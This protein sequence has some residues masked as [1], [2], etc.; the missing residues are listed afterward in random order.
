M[1]RRYGMRRLAWLLTT[2][3]AGG[4]LLQTS[5]TSIIADGATGLATSI[6]D[7]YIRN[8]IYQLLNLSSISS[9]ST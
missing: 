6:A 9:L 8:L 2:I 7:Q 3:L 4:T 5:C 1:L